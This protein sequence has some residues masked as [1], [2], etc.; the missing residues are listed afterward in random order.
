MVIDEGSE[1]ANW[2]TKEEIRGLYWL[3]VI[4]MTVKYGAFRM[5]WK[6]IKNMDTGNDCSSIIVVEETPGKRTL[7]ECRRRLGY[8][9]RTVIILTVVLCVD[10]YVTSL[11]SCPV[12]IRGTN[13][14]KI[15][16]V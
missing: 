12:V 4:S 9:I 13:G 8:D 15:Q 16:A 5:D 11:G 6:N 14:V 1:R 2:D 10:V 7:V 3:I